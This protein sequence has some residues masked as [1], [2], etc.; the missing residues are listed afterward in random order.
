VGIAWRGSRAWFDQPHRY[1]SIP[2]GSFGPLFE[3]PGVTWISL[4]KGSAIDELH[5]SPAGRHV[6]QI[7]LEDDGADLGDTAAAITILDLVVTVDTSIAHLAGAVGKPTFVLLPYTAWWAW[8][9]HGS[10]TPWYPT[11]RLFRQRA[12]GDWEWPIQ[13]AKGALESLVRASGPTYVS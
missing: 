3:V 1:R 12:P 6:L 4:Q 11:F 13:Q 9:L 2:L 5:T 10:R 7:G 8:S